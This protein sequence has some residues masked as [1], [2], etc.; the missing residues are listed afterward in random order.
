[1]QYCHRAGPAETLEMAAAPFPTSAD[2]FVR[3]K[4]DPFV[5]NHLCQIGYFDGRKQRVLFSPL[6]EWKTVEE[7]RDVLGPC[8]ETQ[9]VCGSWAFRGAVEDTGVS[10]TRSLERAM[11]LTATNRRSPQHRSPA[12]SRTLISR[13]AATCRGIA[14]T[15]SCTMAT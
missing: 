7:V 6:N 11:I 9:A 14:C 5:F 1:V 13:R 4:N 8:P 2:L 15:S 10:G 12:L 3:V